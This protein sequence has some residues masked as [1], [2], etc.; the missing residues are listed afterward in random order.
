MNWNE[1]HLKKGDILE[2]LANDNLQ[3]MLENPFDYVDETYSAPMIRVNNVIIYLASHKYHKDLCD[4]YY[5][6]IQDDDG[7]TK[8]ED[9][10]A[11][12]EELFLDIIKLLLKNNEE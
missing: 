2:K 10:N 12:L 3:A 6:I 1:I 4:G 5:F 11:S 8:I 9:V 7:L